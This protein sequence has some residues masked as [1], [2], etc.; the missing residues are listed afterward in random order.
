MSLEEYEP[1]PEFI[2]RNFNAGEIIQLV[3]KAPYSGH[4]LSFK[5]V[6]MVM[7]HELAH[8]KQMNHSSAFWKIRNQYAGEMKDLWARGYTGDGFWS[9]GKTLLSGQY[10]PPKNADAEVLPE[11]LCGGTFRSSS[12]RKRKRKR[13]GGSG[14]KKLLSY[15]ERQQKRIAKKFGTHGVAL[16]DDEEVRVKLEDGKKPKGK[17]RVAGSARGRDLRAAAALARFGQQQDETVK[18]EESETESETDSNYEE[19]NTHET[20]AVDLDGSRLV[21]SKGNGMI[22]VCKDEDADNIHVKEEMQELQD[23]NDVSLENEQS[24]KSTHNEDGNVFKHRDQGV[25]NQSLKIRKSPQK[26]QDLPTMPDANTESRPVKTPL[27]TD[28]SC[29]ICSMINSFSNL[30]CGACSH[31]LDTTRMPRYWRCRNSICKESS[32]INAMDRGFCGVCGS[33]KPTE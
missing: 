13:K 24:E 3:L 16:G 32:Y 8:C 12:N 25:S 6:V 9:R 4:W 20:P 30:L 23:I 28:L 27:K 21:D 22:R 14:E 18:K 7:M 1:N 31:V 19:S 29:P 11:N 26:T 17:P 10:E 2:G 33:R 5:S 15:A